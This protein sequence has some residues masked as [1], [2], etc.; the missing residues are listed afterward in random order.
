MQIDHSNIF[1]KHIDWPLLT[2]V[3]LLSF[4]G[5]FILYSAK[6]DFA[7][8]QK[9]V[10]RLGLASFLMI[11]FAKIPP[12]LFRSLAP[13]VYGLGILLLLVVLAPLHTLT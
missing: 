13:S 3:L 8:I 2:G 12:R 7:L 4:L 11:V 9:Q 1:R 6:Q 10:L 5:L